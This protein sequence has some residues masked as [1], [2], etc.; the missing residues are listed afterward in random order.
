MKAKR[1]EEKR[2][3][4]RMR[5]ND[6]LPA[7][8]PSTYTCYRPVLGSEYANRCGVMRVIYARS[9]RKKSPKPWKCGIDFDEKRVAART[10][11]KYVPVPALSD[12]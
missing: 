5:G 4:E 11:L 1:R 7:S 9:G 10:G 6:D 2:G 12:L 3:N 8:F